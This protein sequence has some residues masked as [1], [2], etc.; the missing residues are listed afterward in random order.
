MKSPYSGEILNNIH[1]TELKSYK[2]SLNLII[3]VIYQNMY[4]KLVNNFYY[5]SHLSTF[6]FN[7]LVLY[8]YIHIFID[9]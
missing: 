2:D 4:I 5:F 7:Y 9:L 1:R 8:F 6:Y 3:Y